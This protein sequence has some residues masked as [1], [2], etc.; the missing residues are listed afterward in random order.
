MCHVEN[1]KNSF[2]DYGKDVSGPQESEDSTK[3]GGE[4]NDEN[5]KD[6]VNLDN[7]LNDNEVGILNNGL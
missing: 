2:P 6:G 3:T 7:N 4:E 1:S 5:R